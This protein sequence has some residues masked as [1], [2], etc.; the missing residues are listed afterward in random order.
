MDAREL[1]RVAFHIVDLDDVE[2]SD[3]EGADVEPALQNVSDLFVDCFDHL[4]LLHRKF[5]VEQIHTNTALSYLL[6]FSARE[7]L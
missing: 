2:Y 7:L 5:R 6:L 4:G 1:R 3:Y